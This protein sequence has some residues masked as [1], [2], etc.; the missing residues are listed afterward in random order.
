MGFGCLL[1][2]WASLRVYMFKRTLHQSLVREPKGLMMFPT[3]RTLSVRQ[4]G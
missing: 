1:L 3:M 2:A 4:R